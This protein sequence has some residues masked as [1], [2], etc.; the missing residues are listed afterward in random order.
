M[1]GNLMTPEQEQGLRRRFRPYQGFMELAGFAVLGFVLS[2]AA[3]RGDLQPIVMG[4]C[5][6][7][8]SGWHG[9]AIALGGCAG[10]L[11][12]WGA[13]GAQALA[14][15]VGGLLVG[16]LVCDRGIARR[17]PTLIPALSALIVAG[18]GVIFQIRFQ[19]DTTV[20]A[21]LLRVAVGAGSAAVFQTCRLCP[22]T[23]ADWMGQSLVVLALAQVMP[24]RLL[25]YGAA[26]MIAAAGGFPAAALSGMALD[27][28]HIT[29]VPMAGAM[30]AAFLLRL[31]PWRSRWASALCPAFGYGAVAML[32]GNPDPMPLPGLLLGGAVGVILPGAFGMRPLAHRRGETAV[33]QVRLEQLAM[34]FDAMEQSL[35]VHDPP[36]DSGQ[37]MACS[38][39][40]ACGGCPDRRGCAGRAVMEEMPEIWGGIPIREAELPHTCTHRRVLAAELERGQERLRRIRAD[41]AR[42]ASYRRALGEQYGYIALYLQGL[43]DELPRA[44]VSR[45]PRFCPEVG[46]STRSR[47][48]VNGDVCIW[49][50]GTENRYYVL[51]C[52]G[53]GTGSDARQ[54]SAAGAEFLRR[55][56]TLGYPAEYA[57]R[58]LNHMAVL[59]EKGACTTVDLLEI[60]LDTGMAELYKW[61]A[62]PSYLLHRGRVRKIGTAGPP[63]GLSQRQRERA[64][65]LSLCGGEVLMM[66]SDG[67]GEEMP[68]HWHSE[69]LP[70]GEM[71]DRIL[72]GGSNG[73]DD[74]TAVMV[75]L[76]PSGL[77]TQ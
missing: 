51:L 75:R 59:G 61:G 53:M 38:V 33:A 15:M 16:S 50:S 42:Q 34:V 26:G 40:T 45:E 76:K 27:L 63:P 19:D 69:D 4:L 37:I 32:T 28:S 57:L 70:L 67:A 41:R 10:Y 7:V 5:C 43:A 9:I 74:A 13:G 49:F 29:H 73:E 72:E 6:A 60:R 31:L 47:H 30:T 23:A 21:F 36:V 65:R 58:S 24:L 46:L 56:L 39:E 11:T 66:L 12:F 35:P 1:M 14:W 62:A 77:S 2:A 48:A 44:A 71:A 20:S 52:D 25:G 64:D 8:G 22:G 55:L 17:Q 3:L 54:E 68:D 18:C